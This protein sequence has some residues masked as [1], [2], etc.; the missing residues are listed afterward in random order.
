MR[1]R[2]IKGGDAVHPTED[3]IAALQQA[4]GVLLCVEWPNQSLVI[5]DVAFGNARLFAKCPYAL[6]ITKVECHLTFDQYMLFRLNPI[7]V[8]S[9]QQLPES[10]IQLLKSVPSHAIFPISVYG[11]TEEN[12]PALYLDEFGRLIPQNINPKGIAAPFDHLMA[13]IDRERRLI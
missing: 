13:Q 11:Y 1:F 12:R 3:E 8:A 9:K 6:M 4:S 7:D 2:D 5:N 10:F